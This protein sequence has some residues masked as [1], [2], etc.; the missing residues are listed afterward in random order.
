MPDATDRYPDSFEWV[1]GPAGDGTLVVGE[2]AFAPVR[3]EVYEFEVSGLKVV[4]SWL[5][6]RMRRPRNVR[7]SSPLDEIRPERWTAAFTGELLNVLW[8]LEATLETYPL[9]RELL[10]RIVRGV[11]RE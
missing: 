1:D 8:I 2:G 10:E 11:N 4:Q 7:K 3:R 6:Y 5:N 9:Q